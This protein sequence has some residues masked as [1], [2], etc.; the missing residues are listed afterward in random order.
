LA[1]A[2]REAVRTDYRN[3]RGLLVFGNAFGFDWQV[4]QEMENRG[5]EGGKRIRAKWRFSRRRSSQANSVTVRQLVI[6]WRQRVRR[7]VSRT[8]RR[9][10]CE[11]PGNT[12]AATLNQLVWGSSPH[13]GTTFSV[14][15][16]AT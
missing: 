9:M 13:R 11:T 3:E 4:G 16:A 5:M 12:P 1:E 14:L 8:S 15:L 6:G 7:L 2:V 10:G